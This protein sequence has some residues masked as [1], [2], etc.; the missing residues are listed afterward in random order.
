M[1]I[2]DIQRISHYLYYIYGHAENDGE[3]RWPTGYI[4]NAERG[5][6]CTVS[7]KS[8]A[9]VRVRGLEIKCR[10]LLRRNI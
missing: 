6:E 3:R 4:A 10:S 1:Y 9:E 8:E 2:Y 7:V 5:T